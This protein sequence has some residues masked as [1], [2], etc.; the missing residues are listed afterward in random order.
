SPLQALLAI[1]SGRRAF[2]CAFLLGKLPQHAL[3][4]PSPSTTPQQMPKLPQASSALGPRDKCGGKFGPD[5]LDL[6]QTLDLF[7]P[8]MHRL[9][10]GRW[11]GI[12][13]RL[14]RL[15]HSQDKLQPLQFAQDFGPE[16]RRQRPTTCGDI[17]SAWNARGIGFA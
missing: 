9:T 13:L 16:P 14:D 11:H 15:D 7:C 6:G 8:R 3:S 2:G 10:L 12:A 17:A 4:S 5:A 1:A